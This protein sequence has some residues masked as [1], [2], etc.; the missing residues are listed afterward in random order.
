MVIYLI[1]SCPYL[2]EHCFY[3][4]QNMVLLPW[5]PSP[6]RT[7]H[8]SSLHSTHQTSFPPTPPPPPPPPPP[9]KCEG[10]AFLLFTYVHIW[11]VYVCCSCTLS[12]VRCRVL[13]WL[14]IYQEKLTVMA[15]LSCLCQ[16][17]EYHA[18]TC[19]SSILLIVNVV[20]QNT[21]PILSSINRPSCSYP[22]S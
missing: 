17:I 19:V 9:S 10:R 15:C 3:L 12:D 22:T 13:I 11:F 6:F 1:Y 8:P 20:M 7:H 4:I 18:D 21:S 14:H 2:Y 5:T 16:Q